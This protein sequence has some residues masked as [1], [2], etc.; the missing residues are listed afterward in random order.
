MP[1]SD[2]RRCNVRANTAG[3]ASGRSVAT[4]AD[5]GRRHVVELIPGGQHLPVTATNRAA[6]VHLMA[7]YRLNVQLQRSVRAFLVGVQDTID[8]SLLRLFNQRELQTL[9]SG[10]SA[11][12]DLADM[13]T[14]TAYHAPYHENHPTILLFWKVRSA[15]RVHGKSRES[16]DK[17]ASAD[18]VGGP[19]PARFLHNPGA[20]DTDRGAAGP[21]ASIRDVVLTAAAPGL[22]RAAAIPGNPPR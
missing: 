9:I 5:G 22:C 18:A 8:V 15:E 10:T 11:P 3:T 4:S 20:A 21:P 13:R 7:H 17:P 14:H 19:S 6:Y 2:V 1:A 16:L 12:V